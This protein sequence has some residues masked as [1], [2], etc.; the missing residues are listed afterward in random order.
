MLPNLKVLDLS[1][2]KLTHLPSPEK[3]MTKQLKELV[4]A[5]NNI[6]RIHLDTDVSNWSNLERLNVSHNNLKDIPKEIGSLS[7]LA[8]LDL[9][10]NTGISSLPD[11]MGQLSNLWDLQLNGIKLDIEESLLSN[12][13]NL[14]AFLHSKLMN[15]VPYYRM[16]LVT[17]GVGG[18]GK[19]TLLNQLLKSK[20][21]PSQNELVIRDWIVRDSKATC[22]NCHHKSVIYTISTWDFKGR[23]DLYHVY[24]GLMSSRTLYLAVYDVAKGGQE[25][26]ELRP[27]LQNIHACAPDVPVMLVGTHLD[28]IPKERLDEVIFTRILEIKELMNH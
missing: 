19:T 26:E 25:F 2:N 17:V 1:H 8:L 21:A 24:Q 5:H 6:K 7:S 12:T 4:V 16:K 3:W 28:T 14:I 9:S 23:E 11:E 22:K 15:S 18:R 10:H 20:V 27:W 13:K